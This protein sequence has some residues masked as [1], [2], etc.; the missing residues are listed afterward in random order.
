MFYSSESAF[1]LGLGTKSAYLIFLYW[2][3]V[4]FIERTSE[5]I[6]KAVR[7]FSII[8]YIVKS[9]KRV[10]LS[11][12]WY[13]ERSSRRRGAILAKTRLLPVW[14]HDHLFS[15]F[16]F[17]TFLC[18]VMSKMDC[19]SSGMIYLRRTEQPSKCQRCRTLINISSLGP[20]LSSSNK[21]SSRT[22]SLHNYKT[23]KRPNPFR[24][25]IDE[26]ATIPFSVTGSLLNEK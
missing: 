21:N 5:K 15:N 18:L 9:E 8:E 22:T 24:C 12:G 1:H 2:K 26:F 10:S 4:I 14:K 3:Y 6:E 13:G 17:K 20:T 23:Q 19:I 7:F 16:L 11:G 25:F